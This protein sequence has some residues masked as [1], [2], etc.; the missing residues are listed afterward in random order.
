MFW[1]G[2]RPLDPLGFKSISG[3]N[4]LNPRQQLGGMIIVQRGVWQNIHLPIFLL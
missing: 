1:S 3:P 2:W 4:A